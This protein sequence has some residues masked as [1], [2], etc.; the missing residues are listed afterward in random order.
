M[1]KVGRTWQVRPTLNLSP[2]R[3]PPPHHQFT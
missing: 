3:F 1:V 2:R